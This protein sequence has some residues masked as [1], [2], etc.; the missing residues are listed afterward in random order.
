MKGGLTWMELES[1][2]RKAEAFDEALKYLDGRASTEESVTVRR[3]LRRA[4]DIRQTED[5]V[6]HGRA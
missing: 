6:R 5:P 1:R 3:I 4:I 2:K